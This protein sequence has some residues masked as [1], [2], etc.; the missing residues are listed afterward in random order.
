MES[1]TF[2]R[3][4]AE[5]LA[6]DEAGALAAVDS[7]LTGQLALAAA[8]L[9]H[10]SI[11]E[12]PA[13][14][15]LVLLGEAAKDVPPQWTVLAANEPFTF[16]LQAA[17][18]AEHRGAWRLSLLMLAEIE[19]V[20]REQSVN[21]PSTVERI[22]LC[23]A[24]RGRIARTMGELEHAVDCYDRARRAVR[25]APLQDAYPQAVLGLAAA[26]L[27]RGNAPRAV[28]LLLPLVRAGTTLADL[29]R[30]PAHQLMAVVRRRQR[31]YVDAM[32]HVWAAFDL[33]NASDFR[34]EQLIGTMADIALDA[35]DADAAARGFEAVLQSSAVALVR[36][37][38]LWGAIQARLM[39]TVTLGPDK[40]RED[41]R[42]Q[43]YDEQVQA[44]KL[45]SI[46]PV[47]EV[48][49]HLS[50]AALA[51]ARADMRGATAAL[52]RAD[53]LAQQA[54]FF[55]RQF[56]IEELRS[57]LNTSSVAPASPR[58]IA[59]GVSA[60]YAKRSRHPALGR[61]LMLR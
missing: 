11:I 20:L 55:D 3:N 32:L 52:D 13:D 6:S 54:G 26:A 50:D 35:G 60:K 36:V 56:L 5:W 21:D 17:T 48:M 1:F 37:P 61:L 27:N 29:Y 2:I 49:V 42:L 44:L 25:R 43:Q 31:R 33:L 57:K 18:L 10:Q 28:R 19:R 9:E 41:V 4:A 30:I 38:A 39:Q 12:L 59:D 47:V 40:L 8:H 24:R 53:R 34:R 15:L 45:Q 23:W 16:W 51:V 58:L 22:A 14:T 46:S 7:A